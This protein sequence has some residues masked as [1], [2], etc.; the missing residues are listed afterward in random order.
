MENDIVQVME[1]I[2]NDNWC[3]GAHL[4]LEVTAYTCY[5]PITQLQLVMSNYVQ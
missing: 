4:S 1:Y 2:V 5:L 3:E